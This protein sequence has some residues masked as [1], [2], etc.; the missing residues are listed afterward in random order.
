MV[1]RPHSIL[2]WLRSARL[3]EKYVMQIGF[4]FDQTRCTGCGACQVACK[5]W[6]DLAA[7]AEKWM[8]IVYT[9]R[10]QC[11]G[12]FV[13]YLVAP[14]YHC[15][16]PVCIPACPVNAISKR[17]DDGIVVVDKELCLGNEECDTKCLK[18]C[19]YDAPQ[20][21]P[22][23]GAKMRKCDFCLDRWVNDRLPVCVEACPTRALDAGSLEELKSKYGDIAEA[24][25]FVYSRRAKPAIVFKPKRP[26]VG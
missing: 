15:V 26:H 1:A 17:V 23:A 7:G 24:E 11:P 4:Y 6:H 16:D 25:G 22:D 13:S 2:R 5:D 18:A 9:E 10:G 20:F 12:V 3:S 8:R 19:P 14:C 21:G